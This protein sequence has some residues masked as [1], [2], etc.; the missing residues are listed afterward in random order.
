MTTDPA[1]SRDYAASEPPPTAVITCAVLELEIEH[2]GANLRHIV[3]IETL[4]QGLHND[5]PKL[6][7][8]LQQAIERIEQ[9][10]TAQA[11]VLGYGLC[12]RGTEG[13]RASRCQVVMPRA[14]DCITLLLGCKQRYTEYVDQHP[15]TYWYSPGWNT[16]HTPPGEDRY[17]QLYSHY[18]E[19]YGEDNAKYLMETEQKWFS[20]YDRATYVD[21]GVGDTEK[22]VQYTRGCA[23]WLGWQFDHQRGDPELLRA[24][25]EGRW[26]SE[27]FVVVPPGQTF[28]MTSD[29]RVIEV[30][31]DDSSGS[32]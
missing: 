27:R 14:H 22:D 16:H 20:T 9:Q 7:R 5:P 19:K 13:V 6:K 21:L 29:D 11:I 10:T 3:H 30:S 18:V 17:E 12:S 31:T 23:K 24:L 4:E 26:D 2:F 32:P 25:L 28:C 15:G 8:E 1:S